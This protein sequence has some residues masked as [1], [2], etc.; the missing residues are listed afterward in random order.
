LPGNK[1]L[2]TYIDDLKY[3]YGAKKIAESIGLPGYAP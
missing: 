2:V 3:Y 1:I